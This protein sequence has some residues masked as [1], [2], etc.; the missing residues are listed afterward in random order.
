VGITAAADGT[1]VEY[2]ISTEGA[3][4]VVVILRGNEHDNRWEK[5]GRMVPDGWVNQSTAD[6][7]RAVVTPSQLTSTAWI[8]SEICTVSPITTPPPSSGS[9]VSMP[10]PLRLIVVVAEKPARVP[11]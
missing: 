5:I 9:S 10:K 8:S 3:G 11:P 1:V 2:D 7:V 6:T 4:P